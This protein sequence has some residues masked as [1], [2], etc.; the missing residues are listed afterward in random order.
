MVLHSVQEARERAL[1]AAREYVFHPGGRSWNEAYSNAAR[2]F[3]ALDAAEKATSAPSEDAVEALAQVL[4]ETAG[5]LWISHQP[6]GTR[7][8]PV[9]WGD[10]NDSLRNH[11]R[12]MSRAALSAIGGR[13]ASLEAALRDLLDLQM[14]AT[15]EEHATACGAARAVLSL[16][17]SQAEAQVRALVEAAQRWC[18][19]YRNDNVYGI[20]QAEADLR[21]AL[22]PFGAE[23]DD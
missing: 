16:Q 20:E 4:C 5:Y 14:A 2:A 15:P 17:P 23:G 1:Q 22:Q 11:Y 3:A 21:A 10:A 19:C 12:A 7:C 6:P 9:P 18:A 13:E 8:V